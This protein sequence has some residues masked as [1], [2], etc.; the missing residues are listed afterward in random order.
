M[1]DIRKDLSNPQN[2]T[3]LVHKESFDAGFKAGR[4][5]DVDGLIAEIDGL[6]CKKVDCRPIAHEVH[7]EA[8]DAAI[9]VIRKHF[10]KE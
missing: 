7:N 2:A 9:S 5:H 8:I 10:G 3:M 1:T 6:K 4:A